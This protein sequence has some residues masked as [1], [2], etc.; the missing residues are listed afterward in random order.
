MDFSC[1]PTP[2]PPPKVRAS[3]AVAAHI[4]QQ[5]RARNLRPGERICG[6]K[7]LQAATGVGRAGVR[8]SLRMLEH[9]GLI[10]T[11]TGPGGG[12]LVGEPRAAPLGR[13]VEAF[14]HLSGASAEALLDAW[15][16]LAVTC[17]RLAAGR[18]TPQDLRDLRQLAD[19]YSALDLERASF[20][21]VARLN[22]GFV[23][24]TAEAAH[25][26][27]LVLFLD[28]L[29]DL[30]YSAAANR[31]PSLAQRRELLG[32]HAGILRALEQADADAASRR[33]TRH[34]L[35]LRDLLF[36]LGPAEESKR[37]P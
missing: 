11:K 29:I 23:R 22:L 28:A 7:E 14:R 8:E 20:D 27:I 19:E 12:I 3:D 33:M 5:I 25:N 1:R 34:L 10:K 18:A 37:P 16:E 26:P 21:A 13:T 35:A 4:Q 31:P 6:E 2:A 15:L 9:E 32:V 30:I 24:R 17:A 36:Q